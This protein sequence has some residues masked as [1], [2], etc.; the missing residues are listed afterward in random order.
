MKP[1]FSDN[2]AFL[3]E[4][5]IELYEQFYVQEAKHSFWAYRQ[6][7]DPTFI[8]GWFVYDLSMHLQQFLDDLL[9]HKRPK[10]II[11][12]PPQH[13]KSRSLQDFCSYVAGR[14]PNLK[15]IYASFSDDLGIAANNYMQRV[16]DDRA[17]FGRV[18]PNVRLNSK[19]IVTTNI[20]A[21]RF[22]RNA[23]MLE[24]V[25]H[26]GSFRNTTVNGQINGKGLDFGIIDD[27]LKGRAAAR[28]PQ[29]RNK[30]WEWLTDDFLTRFSEYA[31]MIL[32]ATRWDLDDPTGRML[33][34]FP[35]A[36]LLKYPAIYVK[37]KRM[38]DA[39]GEIIP[40]R[41]AVDDPRKIGQP[42]F[43]EHKSLEFLIGQKRGM[44]LSSWESLYQQN[45]IVPGGG[46]FP[47]NKINF[48]RN[49]P[50]RASIA[51]SV[52]Y[53]DKAGT[54]DGGKETAG[55]L[56]HALKDGRFM[57]TD[58]TH[59]HWSAWDRNRIMKARAALD[60]EQWGRVEIWIEQEPGSGGKESAERSIADLR[61][62]RVFADRVTGSKEDRAEPYMAQWQGG[63]IILHLNPAW[64]QDFLNEHEGFPQG[65][66][67]MVDAA[68]GA[69]AKLTGK[70]SKYDSSLSW[71]G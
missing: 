50:T 27:P 32:L 11:E 68:A 40:N 58:V 31:G 18:F 6:Y 66:I 24:F 47:Q 64:N 15:Q 43:P 52:R 36:K 59:G 41:N 65:M 13:G 38:R 7:I 12:A 53:W 28:S 30:T 42:L 22:M 5:D 55:V 23:R 54:K 20:S 3:T 46:Y 19:N 21:S 48:A 69:F 14:A 35:D 1:Q 2:R 10:L 8:R 34:L 70:L 71:V 67:D 56:M 49:L 29:Q 17:K 4:D 26:K 44:S 62:Y 61:G 39:Y 57:I 63:N 25:D 33:K 51:K 16:I 45:P 60:E 37:P 9:A